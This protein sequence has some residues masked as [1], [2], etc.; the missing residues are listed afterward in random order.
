VTRTRRIR[1]VMRRLG[2]CL[3]L[4]GVSP[5]RLHAA[6]A[7]TALVIGS[8]ANTGQPGCEKMAGAVGTRLHELGFT[9]RLLRHPTV[10][11][12]RGAL[13]DFAA[14][15]Q[16]R[17]PGAT[18]IY[19]CAG[20]VSEGTRLFVLPLALQPDETLHPQTQGVVVQ[21][22]LNALSG[23]G[24][25]LYADLGL[26]KGGSPNGFVERVPD[27]LHL[28]VA[29]SAGGDPAVIGGRLA[30]PEVR[31]DQ[32]WPGMVSALQSTAG[33]ASLTLLPLPTR[34]D[35]EVAAKTPVPAMPAPVPRDATASP[36]TID[37]PPTPQGE[38]GATV[39]P[40]AAPT[41]TSPQPPTPVIAQT[42]PHPRELGPDA[43][44]D[45]S[46]A[47]SRTARIQAALARRHIYSGSIDGQMGPGTVAAIRAFQGSLGDAPTGTLTGL[48]IVRL[49]NP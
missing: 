4:A 40:S 49:L 15:H 33:A 5:A 11:A 39:E 38:P 35:A 46:P 31:V 13:D 14:D 36:P 41:P 29:V 37:G 48:E 45:A 16:S 43:G 21:A 20:A 26:P 17:P 2:L 7:G 10:I 6:T 28:A 1:V 8:D 42:A 9:V 23:T 47:I 32:D 18:F 30:D 24:G 34:P 22:L 19:L 3:A 25:T 27:G 12:L 44:H